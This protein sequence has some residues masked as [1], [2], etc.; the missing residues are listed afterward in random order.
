MPSSF[1]SVGVVLFQ[2]RG[3]GFVLDVLLCLAL[4]C[5]Y[6]TFC[7]EICVTFGGGGGGGGLKH[8]VTM[9]LI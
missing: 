8:N 3:R 2:L 9:T 7:V 6:D 1:Y 5:M 4:C